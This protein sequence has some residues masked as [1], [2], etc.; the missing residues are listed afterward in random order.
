MPIANPRLAERE[1]RAAELFRMGLIAGILDHYYG[2]H[3]LC[4]DLDPSTGLRCSM[5]AGFVHETHF[6]HQE[7]PGS[8]RTGTP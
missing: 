1:R 6:R 8:G 2:A 4:G 3:T 7:P 5:G